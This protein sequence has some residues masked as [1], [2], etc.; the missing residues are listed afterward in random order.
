MLD[1]LFPI[2]QFDSIYLHRLVDADIFQTKFQL[3]LIP[4]K[5][6][7]WAQAKINKPSDIIRVIFSDYIKILY[8]SFYRL[9]S[10]NHGG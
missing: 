1:P 2:M 3:F 7:L 10:I 8:N 6:C 9:K 4:L 5:M